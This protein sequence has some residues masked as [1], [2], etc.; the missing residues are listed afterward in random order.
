MKIQ[1]F[2]FNWRNQ[3]Q[4]TCAIQDELSGSFDSVTVINSDD[5]YSRPGWINLGD[6]AYFSDQFRTALSLFN[7]DVLMHVQGDVAYH[8]WK[9]LVKDA[10][11]FI[12]LYHAGIYAPNIDYTWYTSDKVDISSA[13][14]A[15]DRLR[16]VSCTDETVWFIH[17]DVIN[18]FFN[19]GV[20]F[21]ENKM[22]W[23][24]DLAL[25]ALSFATQRLVIR[26]Y[27]HTIQHPLGTQYN[28]QVASQ[29][30]A[31]VMTSMDDD[32]LNIIRLIRGTSAE[33]DV[34]TGHISS[35]ARLSCLS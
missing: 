13:K 29:E 33:R 21:S 19:R 11:K 22:G 10:R 12:S 24:W 4:K 32:I 1:P 16:L 28:K 25:C 15:H 3:Y 2:V 31:R 23:G 14:L 35:R 27:A 9:D 20:D 30:L 8:R 34:L 17:K 26:D 5:H 18:E 6:S 7:A